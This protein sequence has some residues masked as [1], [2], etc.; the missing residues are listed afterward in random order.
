M[1]SLL[2]YGSVNIGFCDLSSPRRDKLRASL[3]NVYDSCWVPGA[4]SRVL[5]AK[6]K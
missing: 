3:P 5:R 4:F 6:S 1:V 2:L